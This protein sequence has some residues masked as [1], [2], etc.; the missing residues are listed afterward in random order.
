MGFFSQTSKNARDSKTKKSAQP[1]IDCN[2]V[3]NNAMTPNLINAA[4]NQ[5][6]YVV[7]RAKYVR[8][9]SGK[10][11]RGLNGGK[12]HLAAVILAFE[13]KDALCRVV[14]HAALNL[15][16]VRVHVAVE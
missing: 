15:A 10:R 12:R 3:S 11:G 5:A 16:D 7:A 4:W 13:A 2:P 6:L 14:R 9:R 1:L 8:K